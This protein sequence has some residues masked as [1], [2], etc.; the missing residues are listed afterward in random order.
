M[1]LQFYLEKLFELEEF[2]K[3]KQDNP[4]AYLCSGFFVRD[5]EGENNKNHLD[6]FIP[7]TKRIISFQ[8][9]KNIEGIPIE[10]EFDSA[11]EKIKDNIDFDF[12]E[13]E[14]LVMNKMESENIKN[15]LQKILLSLQRVNDVNYLIG[16]VFISSLGLIKI[17]INI[18]KN[19]IEE[20][21]KKSFLDMMKIVKKDEDC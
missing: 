16:T 17:K 8:L 7:E 12:S 5:K 3:F 6:F 21:E 19:E 18:D 2:Q 4:N 15:K 11:P 10:K 13:I 20:F 9:D 1:N 14:D